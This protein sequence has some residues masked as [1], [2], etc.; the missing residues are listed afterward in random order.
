MFAH[1]AAH[2]RPL[3]WPAPPWFLPLLYLW[4][5]W[6]WWREI[7][8]QLAASGV[9]PDMDP[10]AMAVAGLAG[11]VLATLSE[12]GCYTLWWRG[13][14]LELPYWRFAGWV[15][16]LS[17]ADLFGMTLKGVAPGA[18]DALRVVIG[19]LAGPLALEPVPVAASGAMAAFG[20]LGILTVARVVATAWA[21]ARGIGRPLA[22]PLV[23]TTAAWLLTRLLIWWSFD[24][25]RGMSPVR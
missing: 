25:L 21:Q 10:G 8:A 22:G 5:G 3:P 13:R 15:A 11:R 4:L 24:L 19:A 17:T 2:P 7:H 1:Q 9:A 14:G 20:T 12:A 18:P 6:S 16:A 23:V